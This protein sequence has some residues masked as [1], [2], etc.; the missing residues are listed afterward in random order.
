MVLHRRCRQ[1]LHVPYQACICLMFNTNWYQ[2]VGHAVLCSLWLVTDLLC[3][4]SE[5]H[6]QLRYQITIKWQALCSGS[7]IY[8]EKE[9]RLHVLNLQSA[10]FV[11]KT[12]IF[13]WRVKVNISAKIRYYQ[14]EVNMIWHPCFN[15]YWIVLLR[16]M[17]KFLEGILGWKILSYVLYLVKPQ[18]VQGGTMVW[19][20]GS[21]YLIVFRT[22]STT[23]SESNKYQCLLSTII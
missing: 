4:S 19:H 17:K 14:I 13:D 1:W 10:T 9:K 16:F 6:S 8:A 12:T 20:C 3:L 7:F 22:L 11:V 21:Y 15:G 18:T 23:V 2:P 5:F